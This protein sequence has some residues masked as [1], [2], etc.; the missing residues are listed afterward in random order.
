VDTSKRFYSG[1]F[2]WDAEDQ[3]DPESGQRIYVLML[4]H[5]KKVAGLGGKPPGFEQAPSVWNTSFATADVEADVAR[6]VEAGGQVLMPPL[7]V[8]DQGRM[9]ACSD[10]TGAGFM[11]W[12]PGSMRGTELVD[13]PGTF[14]WAELMTGDVASATSFYSMVFGWTYQVMDMPDGMP[15][16]LVE[17]G[18]DGIAGLMGRPEDVPDEV[19]DNWTVYFHVEDVDTT[20]ARAHQLGGSEA[21][22]PM[23]VPTVGRI[24]GIVDP[25]GAV[26]S[27]MAPQT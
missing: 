23:D 1:L 5:G 2:G 24:A 3:F 13:E 26:F 6:V 7:D 8:M 17:G 19:P 21:Y 12:Q 4:L 11:L 27:I 25:V 14:T 16:T 15:Y 20:V 18:E 10:P 22:A 9:A